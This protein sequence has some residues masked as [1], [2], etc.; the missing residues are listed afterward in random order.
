M[1]I[2][3]L[4]F[5]PHC[6]AFGGFEVQMLAT[7]DALAEE[8][9]KVSKMD[10]WS[11]NQDFEILQ[12]WGLDIANYENIKWAK[13]TGK[14]VVV[15]ALLS[16]Y[17]T[18][19]EKTR[20]FA[21]SLM[22]KQK[23]IKEMLPFIDSIVVLNDLQ[24]EVLVKNY[25]FP[26]SKI[27]IIPNVVSDFF[28][29]KRNNTQ[30]GDYILT[31]GNICERKNQI[32]LAKAAIKIGLPLVIIGKTI[33][34]EESYGEALEKISSKS[35]NKI[36]WIKGLQE[37]SAE[38]ISYYANCMIFAL[39]SFTEQ[40]PISILEAAVLGKPILTSNRAFGKQDYYRNSMLINPSDENSIFLG[41][42][43]M[44]TAPLKYVPDFEHLLSCKASSVATSYDNMYRQIYEK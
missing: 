6:F 18:F 38:L 15:T 23:I 25:G 22:Y 19:V 17:E 44:L 1:K 43:N 7:F 11:R 13:K 39:P 35:E 5:Q 21:S 16:Y 12:C 27:F 36:T 42:Q 24:A 14:K 33:S 30:N 28:F 26:K 37:N 8:G 10:V 3:F 20:F 4:P 9:V 29:K 41:L 32:S 31:V 34:G 2:N 40:Q